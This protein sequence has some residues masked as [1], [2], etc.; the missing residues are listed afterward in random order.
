MSAL[1]RNE[2]TEAEIARIIGRSDTDLSDGCDAACQ[3]DGGTCICEELYAKAARKIIARF[4][5]AGL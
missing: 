5:E 1:P 4:K 3:T 2:P